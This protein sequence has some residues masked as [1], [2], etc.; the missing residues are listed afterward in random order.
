R[1]RRRLAAGAPEEEAV[2]TPTLRAVMWREGARWFGRLDRSGAPTRSARSRP[3]CVALLRRDAGRATLTVEVVP[4][5][6][7]VAEAAEIL[8]WDKRRI[9]TYISRDSFPQPV[10]KL[11]SGR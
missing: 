5:L 8:E 3:A 2:T 9:F 4:D 6:V 7:G 1:A 10:A 11:V